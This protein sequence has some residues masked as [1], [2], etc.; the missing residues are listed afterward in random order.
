MTLA[1]SRRKKL[2]RNKIV[3]KKKLLSSIAVLPEVPLVV[4]V[5]REALDGGHEDVVVAKE[6]LQD[7]PGKRV[8]EAAVLAWVLKKTR[9]ETIG[10]TILHG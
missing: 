4:L 5:L 9:F 10:R 8:P 1:S 2:K 3:F 7:E 6:V